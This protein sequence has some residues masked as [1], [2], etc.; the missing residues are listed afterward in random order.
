MKSIDELIQESLSLK[1]EISALR[2]KR[3]AIKAEVRTRIVGESAKRKVKGMS[4]AEK[5]ALRDELGS[6]DVVVTPK[7]AKISLKG[8]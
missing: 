1:K 8:S 6:G 2:E 7:P 3:L 5:Q 4:N